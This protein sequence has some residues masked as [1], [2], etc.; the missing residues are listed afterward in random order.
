MWTGTPYV[1]TEKVFHHSRQC[2]SVFTRRRIGCGGGGCGGGG[3][4]AVAAAV[5]AAA[6]TAASASVVA[7]AAAAAA[8]ASFGGVVLREDF[9][10][11][12]HSALHFIAISDIL[13]PRQSSSPG[14]RSVVVSIRVVFDCHP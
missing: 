9:P 1:H 11:G 8:A 10:P 7:V 4:A 5:V 13:T 6:A 14:K 2:R 3:V 12:S